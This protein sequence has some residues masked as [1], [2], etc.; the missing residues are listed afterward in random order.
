ML[1]TISIDNTAITWLGAVFGGV[2]VWL[3]IFICIQYIIFGLDQIGIVKE[4]P[5]EY[6]SYERYTEVI[7]SSQG[8][9]TER[10]TMFI[11]L[12]KA[13]CKFYAK[14]NN[15][16]IELLIKD[17]NDNEVHTFKIFDYLYFNNSF[18]EKK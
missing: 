11:V 7:Y 6:L 3:F 17:I 9:T 15:K 8:T 16:H 14:L 2:A 1:C 10:D 12:Q 4:K 18:I 13:G 5:E